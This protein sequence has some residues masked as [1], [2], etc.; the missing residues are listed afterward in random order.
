MSGIAAPRNTP[1]LTNNPRG[2]IV[3]GGA[4]SYEH[5]LCQSFPLLPSSFLVSKLESPSRGA[6][7]V[8]KKG[9][10]K[11]ASGRASPL[12]RKQVVAQP[13]LPSAGPGPRLVRIN[14]PAGPGQG[15]HLVRAVLD[16]R[17]SSPGARAWAGVVTPC[18]AFPRVDSNG[19]PRSQSRRQ[20]T[21]HCVYSVSWKGGDGPNKNTP[22]PLL[23]GCIRASRGLREIPE[24][25]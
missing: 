3:T 22:T 25:A 20:P 13:G 18:G 14:E 17:S 1:R 12:A 11:A 5:Y 15:E 10:R 6:A 16:P 9:R 24:R 7:T 2:R 21:I 4:H 8:K 23:R 19:P